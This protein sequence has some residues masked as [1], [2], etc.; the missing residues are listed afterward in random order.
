MARPGITS[1][2]VYNAA[3]RLNVMG[4]NPTIESIRNEIGS[5][6]SSSTIAPLLKAWKENHLSGDTAG[7]PA[8][9]HQ[10][11]LSVYEQMKADKESELEKIRE[12]HQ[13]TE[14]GLID[15]ESKLH[16]TINHLEKENNDFKS[17]LKKSNKELKF[18]SDI[19]LELREENIKYKEHIAQDLHF[20]AHLEKSNITLNI[21]ID[22]L[23]REL[24]QKDDDIKG[25][26]LKNNKLELT[27]DRYLD[28]VAELKSTIKT[29]SE[30]YKSLT[31]NEKTISKLFKQQLSEFT[32]DKESWNK[33]KAKLSNELKTSGNKV[34]KLLAR[35]ASLEKSLQAKSK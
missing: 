2:D 20:K 28:N 10:A 6:G 1:T 19:K 7:L 30:R 3:N 22:S 29:E 35:I 12:I 25:L 17:E 5:I 9:L 34:E 14:A 8:H 33:E 27:C 32:K 15:D 23:N 31:S 16:Q 21:N 11:I 4:I 18:L 26:T 24:K 13:K